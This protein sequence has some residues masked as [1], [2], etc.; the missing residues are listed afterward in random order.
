MPTNLTKFCLFSASL[1]DLYNKKVEEAK[2][3]IREKS[4][5]F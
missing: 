4:S 3:K 1:N 5:I 2:Y